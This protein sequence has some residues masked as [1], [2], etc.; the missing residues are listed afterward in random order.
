LKLKVD[1]AIMTL[2][3]FKFGKTNMHNSYYRI[4]IYGKIAIL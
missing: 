2:S 1:Y 4:Y 3:F